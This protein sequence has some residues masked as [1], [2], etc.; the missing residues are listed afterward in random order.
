[1]SY[2]ALG[3]KERVR[4]YLVFGHS[5]PVVSLETSDNNIHTHTYLQTRTLTVRLRSRWHWLSK[6]NN[7]LS[8]P[9]VPWPC[10]ALL[11]EKEA[12]MAVDTRRQQTDCWTPSPPCHYNTIHC[13]INIPH[14]SAASKKNGVNQ[15]PELW[16]PQRRCHQTKMLRYT[17]WKMDA[18]QRG[19]GTIKMTSG[20]TSQQLHGSAV[21]YGGQKMEGDTR[22]HW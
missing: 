16:K 22:E 15:R 7:C 5:A 8:F 10:G 14:S 4:V 2:L 1:M 6:P 13:T 20:K 18:K 17:C 9:C 21:C 3:E 19:Q 12:K 11:G